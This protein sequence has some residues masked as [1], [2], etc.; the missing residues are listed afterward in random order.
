MDVQGLKS[1]EPS[2]Q[3]F[4]GILFRGKWLIL[5]LT[6]LGLAGGF[7]YTFFTPPLYKTSSTILVNSRMANASLFLD[8]VVGAERNLAQNEL[9][10]LQSRE[11][12]ERVAQKLVTWQFVDSISRQ[13]IKIIQAPED[14]DYPSP[15]LPVEKIAEKLSGAVE[16]EPVPETDVI[17][18]I[19]GSS[20]PAEA[21]LLANTYADEAYQ[22]NLTN[23]RVKSKLF[24]E[25]LGEQLHERGKALA[26]VEDSLRDYMRREGIIALDLETSSLV[27]Q[28]STLESQR[29]DIEVRLKG[30][31]QNLTAY[32]EQ[33][34]SQESDVAKVMA[35]AN[36][37]YIRLLQDQ[38]ARLEVQRDVTVSQNPTSVGKEVYDQK[39]KE[40]DDQIVALRA[41]LGNRTNDYLENLLPGGQIGADQG[42]PA[43]YL[44]QLKQKILETQID[45]QTQN[46]R[47]LALDA[48]IAEYGRNFS[49]IPA[50]S[51]ELARLQRTKSNHERLFTTLQER[52]NEALMTEQ[53]QFG[54]LEVI[55]RASPPS[56]PATPKMVVNVPFGGV[57][58]LGLAI[59]FLFVRER[60]DRRVQSPEDLKQLGYPFLGT[61]VRVAEKKAL[62]SGSPIYAL[63]NP[64]SAGAESY[65]QIRTHLRYSRAEE[66]SRIILMTSS[67]PSEGKTTTVANLAVAFAQAGNRV[68][69]VDADLRRPALHAYFGIGKEPG[70]TDYL[71]GAKTLEQIT[72][73]TN[74]ERLSIIPCGA[75]VPNPTE[76]LGSDTM[77]QFL[78]EVESQYD[79]VFVDSSPIL[80]GT[81]PTIISTMVD[82]TIVIVSAGET[83][84]NDLKQAVEMLQEVSGKL[85]AVVLNNFNVTRAYGLAYGRS[86]Y[87]YY[88][89][90]SDKL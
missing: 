33:A 25:F 23:S 57:V 43:S 79:L 53:S 8:V 81:D 28:L 47:R 7:L 2:L 39:L 85:P 10:V 73:P 3:E 63:E 51:M 24:R 61:I 54:F 88:Y 55:N 31:N 50:K 86:K 15:I 58:G 16:F 84:M 18:I 29:D 78:R 40:I 45:I 13:P 62:S 80:V 21:V 20:T 36:D 75:I 76:L 30:L 1:R 38:L 4:L 65:R 77:K 48:A 35:G 72:K 89:K 12:A 82:G 69:V 26:E 14:E 46:A 11:L 9:E 68:L 19:A 56:K 17:T 90:E 87:G 5:I 67:V 41:K 6:S 42:D 66:Q 44:K 52:Y 34:K 32:R 71:T 49:K 70:I 22:L 64:F 83:R 37:P 74:V 60:L 27:N 59:L